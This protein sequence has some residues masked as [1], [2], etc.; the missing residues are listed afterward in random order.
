MGAVL[1]LTEADFT[2]SSASPATVASL[3]R[4]TKRYAN[5]VLALDNLS[6]TLRRGEIVPMVRANR[7][8]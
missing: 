2:E 3:T 6:L 5:G 4:I 1:E 7:R 8:Q